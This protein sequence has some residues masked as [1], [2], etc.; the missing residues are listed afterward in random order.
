MRG[1]TVAKSV[2]LFT[3]KVK[4]TLLGAA[5]RGMPMNHALKLAKVSEPTYYRWRRRGL[6]GDPEFADF[7]EEIQQA[8]AVH[9][10]LL[11]NVLNDAAT[12]GGDVKT[13]QWL[14]TY[15]H[16]IGLNRTPG[17]AGSTTV[18]VN[19]GEGAISAADEKRIERLPTSQL[20]ELTQRL[21]SGG[22]G[23]G[24]DDVIDAYSEGEE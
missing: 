15:V 24:E 14:L 12:E 20:D 22:G 7:F 23:D 11:L 13:A 3:D 2:Y 19:V 8:Q 9:A 16:G 5:R 4:K 1:A 10:M 21:L 18:N 17:H 6:D